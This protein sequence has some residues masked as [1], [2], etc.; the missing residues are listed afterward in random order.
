MG[1]RFDLRVHRTE[2]DVFERIAALIHAAD[3]NSLLGSDDI[4]VS[5][6]DVVRNDKLDATAR[7]RCALAAQSA[8]ADREA[9]G[10]PDSFQLHE[11]A[12]GTPLAFNITKSGNAPVFEDEYFIAGIIDIAQ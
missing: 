8:H 1:P 7:E 5:D 3:L 11:A 2:K 10:R 9:L 6:F 4:E 12:V